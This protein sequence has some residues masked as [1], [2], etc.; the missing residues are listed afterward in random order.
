MNSHIDD[1]ALDHPWETARI[2]FESNVLP[3]LK[4]EGQRIGA[5]ARAGQAIAGRVIELYTLL[6][7]SFDPV[8]LI[9]LKDALKDYDAAPPVVLA[10]QRTTHTD[11]QKEHCHICDGGLF[12]C[13]V[14]NGAE[15]ELTAEC[16]G[17]RVEPNVLEEVFKG[18]RNFVAGKWISGSMVR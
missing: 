8:T 6:H 11:C 13:A 18:E 3:R 5:V 16:P 4:A 7:R 15:G 9:L 1:M 12:V 2:D 10:H 17:Y 14:C